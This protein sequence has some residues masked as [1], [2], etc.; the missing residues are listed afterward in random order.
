MQFQFDLHFN[1]KQSTWLPQL[2]KRHAPMPWLRQAINI[3]QIQIMFSF[4]CGFDFHVV[5]V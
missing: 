1:C 5:S 4:S 3:L 2:I